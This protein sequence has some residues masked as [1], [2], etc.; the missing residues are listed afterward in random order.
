MTNEEILKEA[1]VKIL[2]RSVLNPDYPMN[3]KLR[4][5]DLI[6]DL[7]MLIIKYKREDVEG[8]KGE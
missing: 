5:M 7:T 3:S 1:Q 8:L 6:A 4:D 2:D